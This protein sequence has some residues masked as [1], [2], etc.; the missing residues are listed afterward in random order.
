MDNK[1]SLE[2][3][4]S[5]SKVSENDKEAVKYEAEEDFPVASIVICDDSGGIIPKASS[6]DVP[7]TLD[8]VSEQD[9]PRAVL[10]ND[11]QVQFLSP[12]WWSR[13]VHRK[14]PIITPFVLCIA[15][16]VTC[17]T[18]LAIMS[19]NLGKNEGNMIDMYD[20]DTKD[21]FQA[22]SMS[23]TSSLS[24]AAPS[25][26]KSI[27]QNI[28]GFFEQH[29][30]GEVVS[31]SSNGDFIAIGSKYGSY[32]Y[33]FENDLWK[34][35]GGHISHCNQYL[36]NNNK[37]NLTLDDNDEI[38]IC[39]SVG[40]DIAIS[41]DGSRILNGA[42]FS[43]NGYALVHEFDELNSNWKQLGNTIYGEKG[44]DRYG[45]LV[46]F[47]AKGDR[48]AILASSGQYIDIYDLT[49]TKINDNVINSWNKTHTIYESIPWRK[50]SNFLSMSGNGKF[51]ATRSAY[52]GVAIY[53]Q[54]DS[55]SWKKTSVIEKKITID[56]F[57]HAL[58]FSETGDRIAIGGK[59]FEL[60]F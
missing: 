4:P 24:H 39:D 7:N 59:T 35:M 38:T 41:A 50:G 45:F 42:A 18:L 47:S 60:I 1:T 32:V 13:P 29:H 26:W 20:H 49:T 15:F 6:R 55:S 46:A 56:Q 17:C 22:I 9:I 40:Y 58:S 12:N 10:L 28:E 33:K 48:A 11:W 8:I 54:V 19:H 52:I 23:P 34:Q 5:T 31:L 14:I 36:K 16:I 25:P 43:D 2:K 57:G 44:S 37:T 30:F 3:L 21:P 51:I 27:G 53:I